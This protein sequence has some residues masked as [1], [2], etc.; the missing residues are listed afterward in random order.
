MRAFFC[1]PV[2]AVLSGAAAAFAAD[3]PPVDDLPPTSHDNPQ[4]GTVEV[5]LL[6]AATHLAMETSDFHNDVTE[7]AGYKRTQIPAARLASMSNR[8]MQAIE[9]DS[10]CVRLRVLIESVKHRYTVLQ[11]SFNSDHTIWKV[12]RVGWSFNSLTESYRIFQ[13]VSGKYLTTRECYLYPRERW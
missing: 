13:A 5:Q 3:L 8:L 7:E 11:R 12:A 2:V 9:E 4:Q 1:L 10:E 6:S